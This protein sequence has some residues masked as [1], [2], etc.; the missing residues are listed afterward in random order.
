[1]HMYKLFMAALFVIT[2]AEDI[3]IYHRWKSKE[4]VY[5]AVQILWFHLCEILESLTSSERNRV[6]GCLGTVGEREGWIT[7]GFGGMIDTFIMLIVVIL[8]TVVSQYTYV[9]TI[10]IVHFKYMQLKPQIYLKKALKVFFLH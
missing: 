4:T 7:K 1:M 5:K 6:S 2:E 8:L 9:K 10:L 3:Q